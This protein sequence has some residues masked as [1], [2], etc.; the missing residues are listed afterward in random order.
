MTGRGAADDHFQSARRQADDVGS[1]VWLAMIDIAWGAARLR[2]GTDVAL[3]QAQMS[4]GR[5][6]AVEHGLD[7]LADRADRLGGR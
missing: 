6:R 3:A 5:R 2:S 7:G 1:P 4:S